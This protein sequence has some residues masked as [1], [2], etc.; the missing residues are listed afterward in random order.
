MAASR[1]RAAAVE[2]QLVTITFAGYNRDW[3]DWIGKQLE[4]R[5]REVVYHRWDVPSESTIEESLGDLLLA[6]GQVVMV[7][8]GW[9]FQLGPRKPDEWNRALREFVA[10]NVDRFAAVT[11]DSASL[12]S[13][14]T[15]LRP[16]ELWGMGPDEAERRLLK[17]LQLP[18][19]E[20]SEGPGSSDTRFPEDEP[21]VWGGVPRRN[22]RFTGREDVL[23]GI[24]R[25]FQQA[26][27]GA[28]V[29]TLFGMSGVGKTQIAAEYIYRFQAA[30]DVVWW[31]PADQR[32]T[33]RQ[34]LAELASALGIVAGPEYG[35][36]IRAVRD[37]L[38]RGRPHSRWL[39]VLDS[40]DE[41]DL[42]ADLLPSGTGHVLITS[43]NR[44]WTEYNTARI[45]IPVYTRQE[46]IAFICRRA[47]RLD[48]VSAN[49][50]ADALEDLPLLLDQTAGWLNDST[51]SVEEYVELLGSESDVEVGLRVAADFPMTFQTAW[52]ILLN[53]L[54][55][56]V[57]ESVDLLRLCVFF[58][59]G[60]IPVGLLRDASLQDWP[61]KLKD[62][63][64]NPLRWNAAVKKL[65]QYSVV[66]TESHGA[67]G[68][69]NSVGTELLHM[70]RM[71]HQTV[72]DGMAE[73]DRKEFSRVVQGVLASAD[74]GGPDN[75]DNWPRYAEIA[76]HLKSANVLESNDPAIQ[77]L[78]L[79]CL[80]YMFSSGEYQAGLTLSERALEAWRVSLGETDPKVYDVVL[81]RGN[82]LR[83]TGQYREAARIERAAFEHLRAESG[84]Q[85]L[86]T[87]RAASGLAASLGYMAEY[88]EA[89]DLRQTVF[90]GRRELFG[91]RDPRTLA[92]QQNLA[93]SL[94]FLGRY[95]EA[96]DMYRRVRDGRREALGPRSYWTL[97]TETHYATLLR[98]LGRYQEALSIQ[99]RCAQGLRSV[100]GPDRIFT[101]RADYNLA[102]CQYRMGH[103]HDGRTVLAEILERAERVLGEGHEMSMMTA[104][105]YAC[106]ERED[107]ALDRARE[108]S[109]RVMRAY[110]SDLGPRHPFT[111][112]ARSNHGLVLRAAG[113]REQSQHL[114]EESLT[115]MTAAVGPDHPWTLGTALNVTASRSL[116]GDAEAAAELSADTARRSA[117]RLGATHPLTLS[118][119]VALAADLRDLH[120]NQEADETERQA[121][122][123]LAETLGDDHV[124]TLSA[125][126][127]TRPFWDFEP[128]FP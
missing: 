83:A 73:M 111:V 20:F 109:E 10:P 49:L 72:R 124:H 101:L 103:R 119:Q 8:S 51:M 127:R 6:G 96:L 70:H 62:L 76:P 90:D 33:L 32:G 12:P 53:R 81:N 91:E 24:Y 78:V 1:A 26:P 25:E 36:R 44:E 99:E 11:V 59:P 128:H 56:T 82:L 92:S 88:D 41:P 27:R 108:V 30:Y 61:E 31:V 104:T 55:E 80:R 38:R 113:E 84:P 39:L 75:P 18:I 121:L 60:T 63:M 14:A 112:G 85:D 69:E 117:G 3:A 116:A 122:A 57:P 40:A 48:E 110:T 15:V 13:A 29:C 64:N 7:L 43:Q 68:Y 66:Q 93:V 28:A 23:A 9:F 123:A 58:A 2:R 74:P 42:I 98:F 100:L 22:V 105:V 45:E 4:H 94:Q 35:E 115:E 37:A 86:D 19:A 65:V 77:R 5:G 89:L 34:R 17:R 120:K 16:A 21:D 114:L 71:V 46:S 125:R 97:Y 118:C 79:R 95:E 102:M 50:L 54:R 106:V 107:G 67:T 47:T 52:S 87:L 126:A